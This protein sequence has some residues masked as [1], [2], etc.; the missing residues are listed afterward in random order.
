MNEPDLRLRQALTRDPNAIPDAVSDLERVRRRAAARQ[1]HRRVIATATVV[2]IVTAGVAVPLVALGHLRHSIAPA[3][4]GPCP[5]SF[6]SQPRPITGTRDETL[7][8]VAAVSSHDAWAVGIA[9]DELGSHGPGHFH[10][11]RIRIL[12]WSGASW[13]DVNVPQPSWTY[14]DEMFNQPI[15]ISGG[16]LQGVSASGPNDAWAVG[17]GVGPIA[18]HWNGARWSIVPTARLNGQDPSRGRVAA[19]MGVVAVARDDAWAVGWQPSGGGEIPLVEHWDGQAWTVARLPVGARGGLTGVGGSGPNDIWAVGQVSDATGRS[20]LMLMLHWDGA[21]WTSAR[22]P[23]PAGAD[24]RLAAVAA[25][26]PNDAWAVGATDSGPVALHWDGRRWG[27]TAI[28]T[29]PGVDELNDVAVGS[30][31]QAWAVGDANGGAS[32]VIVKWVDRAWRAVRVP[33][34]VSGAFALA[35]AGESLNGVSAARTDQIW[36]VGRTWI[37]SSS[38][39]LIEL[40]CTQA[41]RP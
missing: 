2:A 17:Y 25:G 19:L 21:K 23:N 5:F 40:G 10:L 18:L 36:A 34:T 26:S 33:S 29:Q 39:G 11:D 24:D 37:G 1:S 38:R 13:S 15:H 12:H 27:E 6:A 35:D 28:E 14:R 7:D 30:G 20:L 16:F 8:D 9:G 22:T 3:I 41:H 4:S 32:A 31:G